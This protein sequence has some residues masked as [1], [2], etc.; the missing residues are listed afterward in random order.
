VHKFDCAFLTYLQTDFASA[1][2][3]MT[4][5]TSAVRIFAYVHPYTP[6]KNTKWS[7]RLLD[8]SSQNLY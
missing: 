3:Q 2:L 8:Q 6:Y 1:T 7:W 4:F 5:K